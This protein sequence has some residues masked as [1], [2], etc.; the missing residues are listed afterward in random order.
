MSA[1]G[2]VLSLTVHGEYSDNEKDS[3]L[4]Y[5]HMFFIFT[6]KLDAV[7]FKRFIAEQ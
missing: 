2:V 3:T 4:L 6:Q 7:S 5:V 1:L